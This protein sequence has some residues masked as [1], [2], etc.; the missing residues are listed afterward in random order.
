MD[1]MHRSSGGGAPQ[2]AGV[3]RV[4]HAV[5]RTRHDQSTLH[6]VLTGWF[7]RLV[8]AGSR[9]KIPANAGDFRLLDRKVVEALK[10]LPETNRF[11]KGLYAWVGFRSTAIRSEEHTS[12]L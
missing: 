1:A 3:V 2:C 8:N 10:R 12:E 6:A 11:M 5:R 7:Y 9:I 4:P